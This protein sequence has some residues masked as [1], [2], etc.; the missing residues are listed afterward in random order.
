MSQEI[1]DTIKRIQAHKGVMGIIIINN[2]GIPIK[3]TMDNATSVHYA[4]HI[5]SLATKARAVVKEIDS[6]NDLRFLRVRSKKHEILVAPE[7]EYCMIVI[8]KDAN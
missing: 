7:P 6:T 5:H 4:C 8:Q 2:D 1:D 3:S